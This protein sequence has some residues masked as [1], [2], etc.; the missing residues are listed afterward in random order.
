MAI[1]IENDGAKKT[2][3]LAPV[4]MERASLGVR[5]GILNKFELASG[6]IKQP[7]SG[8]NDGESRKSELEAH[9]LWPWRE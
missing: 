5:C 2:H 7:N 8:G 3:Q 4:D 1:Q 9:Q 6:D